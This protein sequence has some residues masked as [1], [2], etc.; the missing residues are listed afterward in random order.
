MTVMCNGYPYGANRFEGQLLPDFIQVNFSPRTTTHSR[1]HDMI[2]V[3]VAVV[4]PDINIVKGP[5]DNYEND[6]SMF[7]SRALTVSRAPF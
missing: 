5:T 1:L 4:N 2:H 6:L 7:R 3:R